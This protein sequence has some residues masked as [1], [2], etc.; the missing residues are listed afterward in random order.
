MYYSLE[1]ELHRKEILFAPFI[2][3]A[4]VPVSGTYSIIVVD[5]LI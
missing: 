5:Q 3:V 4:P 1:R 2:A